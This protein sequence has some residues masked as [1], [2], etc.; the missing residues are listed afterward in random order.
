[1]VH[2]CIVNESAKERDAHMFLY[3]SSSCHIKFFG[4]YKIL[5]YKFSKASKECYMTK[6]MEFY[7]RT[8]DKIFIYTHVCI[9]NENAKE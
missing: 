5:K 9:E 8:T 7:I 3:Y 1:M 2:M 6:W 4:M